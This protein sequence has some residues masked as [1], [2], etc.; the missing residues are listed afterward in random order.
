MTDIPKHI[1]TAG[2]SFTHQIINTSLF[3]RYNGSMFINDQNS[4]DEILRSDKYPAV[5]T[6]DLKAWKTFRDHY[7]LSLNIQNLTDVKFYD[8]KY[9][10]CPGRF[11]T[12]EIAVNF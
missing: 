9:A 3:I 12:A 7:K 10:V 2:T 11:I 1:F 4:W 6:L 8:S 5:T